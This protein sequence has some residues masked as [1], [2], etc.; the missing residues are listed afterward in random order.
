MA[1]TV[2]SSSSLRTG[3]YTVGGSALALGLAT[4]AA[5]AAPL[6]PT[7]L[8]AD[9]SGATD[10]QIDLSWNAVGGATNYNVYRL[11]M[12]PIQSQG[13]VTSGST[14]GGVTWVNPGNAADGLYG[15]GT[16]TTPAG[17]PTYT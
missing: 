10:T 3:I 8:S 6:A 12:T 7:G 11:N 1:E 4:Q 16:S 2:T 5:L 15:T 17:G 13:V 14:A 9:V